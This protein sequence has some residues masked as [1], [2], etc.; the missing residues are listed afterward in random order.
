MQSSGIT[1]LMLNTKS[2]SSLNVNFGKQGSL[3]KIKLWAVSCS[4]IVRNGGRN[5]KG[6]EV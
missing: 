4:G 1:G 2:S 6:I 5:I 3:A